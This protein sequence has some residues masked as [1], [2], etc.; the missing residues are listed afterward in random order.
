MP[1]PNA[2]AVFL[3]DSIQ[4]NIIVIIRMAEIRHEVPFQ[5]LCEVASN[6]Q[7]HQNS[8]QHSSCG[9]EYS[10]NTPLASIALPPHTAREVHPPHALPAH[11]E[12]ES[13]T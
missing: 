11:V 10:L 6:I 5:Q 12:G 1:L 8:R 9:F 4:I 7:T 3:R 13:G 2:G